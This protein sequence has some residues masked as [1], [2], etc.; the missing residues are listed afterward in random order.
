VTKEDKEYV[1]VMCELQDCSEKE[2]MINLIGELRRANS[3]M[4]ESVS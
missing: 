2:F 3:R 1:K 4:V